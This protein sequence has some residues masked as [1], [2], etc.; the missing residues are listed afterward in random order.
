MKK[1]LKLETGWLILEKLYVQQLIDI[2][3]VTRIP[4]YAYSGKKELQFTNKTKEWGLD[5]P[6]HSNG[7]V[8]GD[9]DNDGDLDLLVGE[10]NGNIS[11]FE[12][13]NGED[14]NFSLISSSIIDSLAYAAPELVDIDGDSDLDLL[15]GTGFDG[16]K[17]YTN[18]GNLNFEENQDI[19]ID[20]YGNYINLSTGSIYD[21]DR[22]ENS[23]AAYLYEFQNDNEGNKHGEG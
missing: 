11:Y 19:N 7:A 8:Y 10:S 3:P 13:I 9:L 15:V 12:R 16:I 6:S 20:H 14:V 21:D 2:I 5:E 1:T 18:L 23:G 22:G 17:V 4:N